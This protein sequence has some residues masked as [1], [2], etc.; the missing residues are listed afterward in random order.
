MDLNVVSYS[1]YFEDNNNNILIVFR[2]WKFY[3]YEII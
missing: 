2:L 1:E 3:L